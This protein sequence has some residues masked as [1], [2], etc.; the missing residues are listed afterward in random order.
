MAAD[1]TV[2]YTNE[3]KKTIGRFVPA[4]ATLRGVPARRHRRRARVGH[5]AG[6]AQGAGRRLWA[7]VTGGFSAPGANAILRIVPAATPTVTTYKLGAVAAPFE[8]APAPNGDVWF[9][10]SPAAGDGPIGRLTGSVT[11]EPT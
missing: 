3:I 8:V 11:P 7:A 2:W 1:G 6:A 9:T 4:D 10:G 5:A